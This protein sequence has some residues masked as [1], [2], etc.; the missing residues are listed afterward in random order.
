[1]N[2]MARLSS[3]VTNLEIT[4]SFW[5]F[6]NIENKLNFILNQVKK[7]IKG[8]EDYFTE[9]MSVIEAS[10][11]IEGC[12]EL[13][14]I[15]GSHEYEDVKADFEAW[16]P[17]LSPEG[18]MALHD[19]IS[20]PGV[21]KLIE[22]IINGRDDFINPILVDE[23]TYIRKSDTCSGITKEI[24]KQFLDNKKMMAKKIQAMKG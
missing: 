8:E 20:K 15:D 7:T 12:I 16:W 4:D 11:E 21:S 17:R 22:E 3:S 10:K 2:E 9:F 19:T 1:M 24:K 13:I 14:F 5:D 18:I 23:I 6:S